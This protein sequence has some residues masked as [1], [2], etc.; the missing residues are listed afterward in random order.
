ML[1]TLQIM[2]SIFEFQNYRIQFFVMHIPSLFC[3][4]K[5]VTHERNKMLLIII[6]SLIKH[7]SDITIKRIDLHLQ[8]NT[9]IVM[10]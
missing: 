9:S 5:F 10:L 6:A 4:F 1:V 2:S 8:R 7:V 3:F